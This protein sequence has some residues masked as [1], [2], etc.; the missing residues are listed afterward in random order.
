M[1]ACAE[2]GSQAIHRAVLHPVEARRADGVKLERLGRR[3]HGV[4]PDGFHEISSLD[5]SSFFVSEL[6]IR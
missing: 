5:P 3:E 4:V 6:T 1:V 2:E